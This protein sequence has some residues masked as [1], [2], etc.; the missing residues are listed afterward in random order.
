VLEQYNW[1]VSWGPIVFLMQFFLH[2]K[3][4]IIANLNFLQEFLMYTYVYVGVVNCLAGELVL[5]LGKDQVKNSY[6]EACR[7]LLHHLRSM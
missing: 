1:S 5:T 7:E 6:K 3:I 4:I 2:I